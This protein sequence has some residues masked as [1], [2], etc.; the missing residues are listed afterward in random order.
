MDGLGQSIYNKVLSQGEDLLGKLIEY[1]LSHHMS[2]QIEKVATDAQARQEM[3]K[4][5]G[6]ID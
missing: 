3:Y 6:I 1:L 2:D 5:Y 4:K